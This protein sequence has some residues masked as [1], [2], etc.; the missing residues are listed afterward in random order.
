MTEYTLPNGEVVELGV[1][2]PYELDALLLV[3]TTVE[4]AQIIYERNKQLLEL[5]ENSESGTVSIGCPHCVKY[6]FD[7]DCA[8]CRWTQVKNMLDVVPALG[9]I[10]EQMGSNNEELPCCGFSFGGSRLCDAAAYVYYD[11]ATAGIKIPLY[12]TDDKPQAVAFLE[13][14]MEWASIV[15]KLGGTQVPEEYAKQVEQRG[16]R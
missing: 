12:R 15:I 10:I 1:L 14:H 16:W 7:W 13:G 8:D 3:T 4:Q 6:G 9:S 2:F 5:L 11:D